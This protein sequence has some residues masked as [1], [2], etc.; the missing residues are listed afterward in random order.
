MNSISHT[1]TE[2]RSE[3]RALVFFLLA[4]FVGFGIYWVVGARLSKTM[5]DSLGQFDYQAVRFMKTR[6]LQSNRDGQSEA[7]LSLGDSTASRNLMIET[8]YKRSRALNVLGGSLIEPTLL[9]RDY[10]KNNPA[11]ECVLI[12]TS[13]GA[14]QSHYQNYFWKLLVGF[15]LYTKTG[16]AELYENSRKLGEYPGRALSRIEWWR[17][18]YFLYS[19]DW[20]DFSLIQRGIWDRGTELKARRAYRFLSVNQGAA[21]LSTEQALREKTKFVADNH[22]FM[23]SEF[24]PEKTLDIYIRDLLKLLED[25]KV[26]SIFM[27]PPVAES[28]RTPAS[29]KWFRDY[30]VHIKKILGEF[31]STRGALDPHWLPDSRFVDLNHLSTF[32]AKDYTLQLRAEVETCRGKTSRR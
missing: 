24:V 25:S 9:M 15:G 5:L 29:E 4:L 8:L 19:P 2:R 1:Q 13:Y 3:L 32:W 30:K 10:M 17:N 22:L 20:I 26:S 28:A 11:P 6:T 31:P 21:P 16:Y 18:F 14:L 7:I 12:M 23:Q 27:V